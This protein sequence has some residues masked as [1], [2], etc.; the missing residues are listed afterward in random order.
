LVDRARTDDVTA[1]FRRAYLA[2]TGI[3]PVIFA[4]RPVGGPAVTPS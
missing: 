1:D 2:R 3:D 4:T